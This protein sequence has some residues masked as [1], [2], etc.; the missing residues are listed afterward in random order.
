MLVPPGDVDALT[1]AIISYAQ[2]RSL[3]REQAAAARSRAVARFH[4]DDSARAYVELSPRSTGD[5][6]LGS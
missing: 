2:R 6:L 3:R 1:G 4:I 5:S